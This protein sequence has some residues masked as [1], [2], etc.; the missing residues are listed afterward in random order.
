MKASIWISLQGDMKIFNLDRFIEAQERVWTAVLKE[1]SAG[2]K[3]THWS[4]FIFPQIRGLGESAMS[5]MYAIESTDE[6][7]ALSEHPI[8]GPRL[9]QSIELLSK[10]EGRFTP[11]EILGP[12]D[13]VKL[14][15]CL[16]LFEA[17]L[18]EEP[19]FGEALD[20]LYHGERDQQTLK[21]LANI[22]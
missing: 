18:P 22:A 11:Q 9:R 6:A 15:S 2:K 21:I 7:I 8:L 12:I 5:K 1:L 3:L 16:T 10:H 14:R 17:A 13:A 4:W 20:D 19:L